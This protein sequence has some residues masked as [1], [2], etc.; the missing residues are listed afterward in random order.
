MFEL[1]AQEK[2]SLVHIEIQKSGQGKCAPSYGLGG[3]EEKGPAFLHENFFPEQ[4]KT[5]RL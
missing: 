5:A 3:H 4:K 2:E 1:P